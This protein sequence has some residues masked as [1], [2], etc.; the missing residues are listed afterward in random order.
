MKVRLRDQKKPEL[1]TKKFKSSRDK[2]KYYKYSTI[3][4]SIL[5]TGLILNLF[6]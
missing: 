4:L 3:A 6:R 2:F 1:R 5:S